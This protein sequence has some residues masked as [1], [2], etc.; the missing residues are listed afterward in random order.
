MRSWGEFS[1][2]GEVQVLGDQKKRFPLRS[3]PQFVILATGKMLF[4]DRVYFVAKCGE[5]RLTRRE[6]SRRA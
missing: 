3:L 1:H 6:D 5:R 4:G 2:I